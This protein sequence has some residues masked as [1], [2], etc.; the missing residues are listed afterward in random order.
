MCTEI[1]REKEIKTTESVTVRVMRVMGV[2][3]KIRQ[4]LH[5]VINLQGLQG[6]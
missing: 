3:D 6:G 4:V 2:I 5:G 1:N